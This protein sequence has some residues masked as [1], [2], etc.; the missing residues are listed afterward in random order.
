MMVQ[1]VEI[2]VTRLILI[3]QIISKDTKKVFSLALPA[4]L[5]HLVDILQVLL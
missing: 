2:L 4:A 1:P 3:K 5:K